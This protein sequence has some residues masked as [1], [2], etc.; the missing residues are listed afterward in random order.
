MGSKVKE[1]FFDVRTD[2]LV[3]TAA[4]TLFPEWK[5]RRE[6]WDGTGSDHP[7]HYLGSAIWFTRMGRA[8]AEAMIP[9]AGG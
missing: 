6:E 4:E 5:E 1:G 9:L 2:E 8:F 3:D 7:Y